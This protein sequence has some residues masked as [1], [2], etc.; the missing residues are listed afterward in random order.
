MEIARRAEVT[1][2]RFGAV[3]FFVLFLGALGSESFFLDLDASPALARGFSPL[4]ALLG[5]AFFTGFA[6]T[7]S[8]S[9]S[10]SS[11]QRQTKKR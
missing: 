10:V 5:L 7:S 4:V 1:S 9:S 3:A 2:E 8:A 11:C 6:L